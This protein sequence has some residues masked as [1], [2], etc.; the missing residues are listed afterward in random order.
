M[1]SLLERKVAGSG[2]NRDV[3]IVG[4]WSKAIGILFLLGF[5]PIH[6]R[7]NP[8]RTLVAIAEKDL[9]LQHITDKF[10]FA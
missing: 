2:L 5:R 3:R 9:E 10:L 4:I 6:I 1:A 8:I 7:N